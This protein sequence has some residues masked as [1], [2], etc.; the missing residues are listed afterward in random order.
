MSGAK[1]YPRTCFFSI[2]QNKV[3]TGHQKEK[4][5][6]WLGLMGCSRMEGTWYKV[7]DRRGGS[8][9]GRAGG[10]VSADPRTTGDQVSSGL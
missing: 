4:C 8:Q 1:G 10:G 2:S 5:E 3:R 9:G 6:S 7:G